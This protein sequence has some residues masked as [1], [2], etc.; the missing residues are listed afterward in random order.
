M[1]G[2]RLHLEI[3]AQFFAEML[4]EIVARCLPLA[5]V[6]RVKIRRAGA[7]AAD[8]VAGEA[9]GF[10]LDVARVPQAD[11]Q[12]KRFRVADRVAAVD[13]G[14]QSNLVEQ[15]VVMLY[16]IAGVFA[17]RMVL[18]HRERGAEVARFQL[19]RQLT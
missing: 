19:R 6:A 11:K 9:A 18:E 10:A 1:K 3:L 15:I 17:G 8:E 12:A 14:D 13:A 7:A 5:G 4:L 16:E 2:D